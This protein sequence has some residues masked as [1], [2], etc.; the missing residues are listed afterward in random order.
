MAKKV[1]NTSDEA[2]VKAT[3]KDWDEWF[4]ILDEINA[5]QMEHA[6]IA[7]Y[8]RR[9]HIK[10]PWWC[11]HITVGY[12]T[13]RGRRVLGETKES[14]FEVGISKTI[15]VNHQDAW[16]F[17]TSSEGLA[18]WLGEMHS[19]ELEKG[20][21]YI[22]VENTQGEIRSIDPPTKIRLTYKPAEWKEHSTLQI[23][24]VPN[25]GKTTF[26]FHQENLVNAGMRDKMREHWNDV[27][28][29]FENFFD[30]RNG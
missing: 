29:E 22:T 23:Y 8:L 26:K 10:N 13:E 1:I 4:K 30:K 19:L 5:V 17:L 25:K 11:Q 16:D 28:D 3:G 21:S 27:L 24:L 7:A 18:C 15:N 12:E 6:D 9:K 14:G 20:I 2:V